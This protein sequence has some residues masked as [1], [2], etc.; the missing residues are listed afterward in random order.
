MNR[1]CDKCKSPEG[2][3][4]FKTKDHYLDL[5]RD[6]FDEFVEELEKHDLDVKDIDYK[7]IQVN[8]PKE[9]FRITINR[10][11]CGPELVFGFLGEIAKA[12]IIA[13]ILNALKKLIKKKSKERKETPQYNVFVY[14]Q[15]NRI[16]LN[17]FNQNTI[18]KAI[19]NDRA[20]KRKNKKP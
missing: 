16:E 7:T 3:I 12:G 17:S 20:P 10:H 9:K 5:K 18:L 19:T 6:Q 13:V 14:Q 1:F 11:E 4:W 2:R 15:F 8:S